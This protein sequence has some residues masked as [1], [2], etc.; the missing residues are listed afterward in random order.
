MES[1]ILKA[2]TD[3]KPNR[4]LHTIITRQE[5]L[6]NVRAYFG[7]KEIVVADRTTGPTCDTCKYAKLAKVYEIDIEKLKA[8]IVEY[9]SLTH[10]QCFLSGN[11]IATRLK[12]G[13]T[14]HAPAS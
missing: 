12:N 2:M 7:G 9:K 3:E 6:E 10:T 1:V 14:D 11:P 8:G 4:E 13:C 5:G